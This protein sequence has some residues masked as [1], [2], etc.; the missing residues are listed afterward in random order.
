MLFATSVPV[1]PAGAMTIDPV[2]PLKI[3]VPL[4]TGTIRPVLSE[5][6]FPLAVIVPPGNVVSVSRLVVP[7]HPALE[8]PHEPWSW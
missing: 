1:A 4:D 2:T 5:M 3:P 6:W 7:E 8:V